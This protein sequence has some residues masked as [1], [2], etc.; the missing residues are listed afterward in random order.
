MTRVGVTFAALSILYA[1]NFYLE[2]T[3]TVFQS[4]FHNIWILA[5]ASCTAFFITRSQN[6]VA[7]IILL[8][9][10]AVS[11]YNLSGSCPDPADQLIIEEVGQDIFT[12]LIVVSFMLVLSIY[13]ICSK[14]YILLGWIVTKISLLCFKLFACFIQDAMGG[15]QDDDYDV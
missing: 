7:Y 4:G 10:S 3:T 13:A 5:T 14:K 12:L 9:D 11:V 15:S 2:H 1:L 6:N 8:L